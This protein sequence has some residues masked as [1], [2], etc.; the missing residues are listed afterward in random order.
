MLTTLLRALLALFLIA[1]LTLGGGL[2]GLTWIGP[3]PD[4]ELRAWCGLM[5]FGQTALGC[6]LGG[7][8]AWQL[9]RRRT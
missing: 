7:L 2:V 5:F 6:G 4:P 8:L 1:V 3:C 9:V